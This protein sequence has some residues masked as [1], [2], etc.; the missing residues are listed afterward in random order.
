MQAAV[1]TVKE[2]ALNGIMHTTWHTLSG[3]MS[4]VTM[5]AIGGFESLDEYTRHKG[6]TITA[7]L[8]RRVM[9]SNGSYEDAGWAK[10]QIDVYWK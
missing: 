6:G 2:Q 4:Y 5:A 10:K 1:K 9:P 3:K 8:W 7:G